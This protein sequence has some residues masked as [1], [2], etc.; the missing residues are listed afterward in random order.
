MID[1]TAIRKRILELAYQGNLSE[2]SIND[3]DVDV[4]YNNIRKFVANKELPE[5]E[6][7]E[8]FIE[9]PDNWKWVRVGN[10][11]KI[12]SKN[13]CNDNEEASF[14]PMALVTEGFHN[15][16]TFE[17]KEW[18]KIKKGFNHLLE[19]DI[20]VA[21]ITPCF[22]NRKS[23]VFQNLHNGFG[24]CTTE[25]IVLRTDN[26][27]LL[28]EYLLYFFKTEEFIHK[29]VDS[30]TGVVGQQRIHKDYLKMSPI[31]LPP[32]EEQ[33]RIVKKIKESFELLD[34]IDRLQ[35]HYS[36]DIEILKSKI[37]DAGIQGKL[38]EQ[39]PEDGSAEELL[40]Q[41]AEEKKRL[42]K[43]KKIKAT[44]ALPEITE[45]EIPFVIPDNWKWVRFNDIAN[46]I[47]TGMIRSGQEQYAE[48]DYYYFK[49]NNIE[50]FTGKCDFNNM[51]M[52]N[53]SD[54]EFERYK[55]KDGDFLFNT[56]N[57]AELVGKTAVVHNLPSDR[58]LLNNNI[59]KALFWGDISSDYVNYFFISRSGR[60][61]L[62]KFITSTTNVAAIYQRQII[63]LAIPLPPLAEQKRIVDTITKILEQI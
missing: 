13:D 25:L 7:D 21:K 23:V 57:S 61:Q 47:G 11:A 30:F 50:N 26:D 55:L 16:H 2:Q 52:V 31:P 3:G 49:M 58:I 4:L 56:R 43:E 35:Q 59:L 33:R 10:I 42:V 41:I 19:G 60:R 18:G 14:I 63:T 38:T 27:C 51:T 54:E 20:G 46:I 6:F 39:L 15:I 45:D 24:A 36:S 17:I 48:A 1:T 37:I 62:E 53:A 22:Q 9:I 44:K 29:G 5:V 8:R 12:N 32:V 40:E 28:N 34:V